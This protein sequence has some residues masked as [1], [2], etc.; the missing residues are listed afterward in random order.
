VQTR[1]QNNVTTRSKERLYQADK[2][3]KARKNEKEIKG[4][5]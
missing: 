3:K 4:T 5:K 1:I 2:Q